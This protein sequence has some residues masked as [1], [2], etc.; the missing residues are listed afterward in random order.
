MKH[1]LV[2]WSD[3]SWS[4]V[5]SNDIV[6]KQPYNIGETRKVKWFGKLYMGELLGFAGQK[7]LGITKICN[8]FH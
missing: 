1:C 7:E 8:Y 5:N 2:A 4:V 3:E 6:G